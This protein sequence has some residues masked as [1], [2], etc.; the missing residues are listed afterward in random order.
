MPLSGGAPSGD[1]LSLFETKDDFFYALLSDGMGTGERAAVASRVSC[2]FLRTMLRAGCGRKATIRML[3]DL[4]RARG[5]EC[6]ATVDILVFDLLYGDAAFIKSGAAP[7][8][9]KRGREILRVRSRTM[10]L[11]IAKSADAERIHVTVEEGDVLILLSDG[12]VPEE[13]DPA[14]LLS[15]L[16]EESAADLGALCRRI[17]AE[18]VSKDPPP[19]DDMTVTAIKIL[20][21]APAKEP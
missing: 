14:W 10:P 15:L 5:E 11:G 8:Y 21:A 9:I 7:S 2:D 16:S 3:N 4:V 1:T 20:P 6:S 17:M 18:A 13:E 19:A 12:L